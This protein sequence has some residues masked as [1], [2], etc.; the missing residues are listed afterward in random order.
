MIIGDLTTRSLSQALRGLEAQRQ[1]HE[2]NIAN[3]ETPGYLAKH[4]TFEDSLRRAVDS[5]TPERTSFSTEVSSAA[6]RIDGNNVRIDQELTS[7]AE[8]EL[9]QRLVTEA[10]ND[11]YQLV[12]SV[13]G[14]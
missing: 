14:R 8:N 9:K 3:V 12:R 13:L 5:G 6:W 2:Q 7:L 10:L 11:Q 1:A 4:V